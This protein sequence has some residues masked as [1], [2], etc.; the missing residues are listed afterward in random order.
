MSA[1]QRSVLLFV[2]FFAVN[3]S[4][5]EKWSGVRS[6][7][8]NLVGNATESQI[9]SAAS[10]LEQF[11]EAFSQTFATNSRMATVP[12][13]V[14]VFKNDENARLFSGNFQR[15]EDQHFIT[16]TAGQPIPRS[17]Y[18][19]YVHELSRDIPSSVPLW[20]TEGLAEFYSTFEILPR[21]RKYALGQRI[22]EHVDVLKKSP[23][24]A[25]EEL[26]AFDRT[27]P[28]Y[29]E[30]E[31]K[32]IYY[33][34][35]WALVNYL[36]V[37]LNSTRQPQISTFVSLVAEGK[38]PAESFQTAFKVDYKS[39]LSE[40]DYYV[41]ERQTWDPRGSSL[42]DQK[43][44]DKDVRTRPLTDAE[45]E[46]YFGDLM[47]HLNRLADAEVHLKQATTLDP[48]L[49]AAQSAMGMLRFRQDQTDESV[50]FLK[51]SVELDPKNYLTQYNYA[52][53]LDK[54]STSPLD[55]LDAKR[56]ALGQAVALAPNYA[57][58]YELLA[59]IN[60]TA[61][62][63]YNG[64]IEL[65]QTAN[66]VAPGNLNL[67]FLMAQALVK[68]ED[69]DQAGKLLAALVKNN[70]ADR[71][72]RDGAQ[73]L[74]NYIARL[75]ETANRQRDESFA[76]A[77]RDDEAAR[78]AAAKRA[79]APPVEVMEPVKE[80]VIPP[81]TAPG[82]RPRSGELIRVSPEKAR[83]AGSKV[84]GMLTLMD[85]RQGVTMTIKSDSGTITLHSDTPEKI[86]FVSFV[87]GA[88]TEIAC[89]PARGGGIPVVVTYR[90]AADGHHAGEPLEVEFVQK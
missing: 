29:N 48:R 74:V 67:R 34:Q 90:P 26:F 7:N 86:S 27:S 70:A 44:I 6:K 11:R 72:I 20:F 61:D 64:T 50:D 5:A 21:D 30:R 39:M 15:G 47:L 68:K 22:P 46:Y 24:V 63:D 3:A 65:L 16:L 37:G 71:S 36:I 9:R 78:A 49:A 42:K 41:R 54:N 77:K 89:G 58:A 31:R 84:T 79:A 87:P 69:F 88:S 13:T 40:V 82:A 18:H 8:F 66:K 19:Q 53:V 38:T 33:A 57:P 56:N 4:A 80:T 1:R 43:E 75:N 51:R 59:Y 52:F 83:P 85:C 62:I 76:A 81:T 25:L 55:N 60:L 23:L 12:I 32:G 28:Q 14:V 73:N 2:L 45:A 17:I 10:D 35:S